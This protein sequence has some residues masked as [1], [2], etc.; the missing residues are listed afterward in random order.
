MDSCG[1]NSEP[2]HSEVRYFIEEEE[3]VTIYPNP[4]D[5]SMTLQY[6]LTNAD[7]GVFK[8]YDVTGKLIKDIQLETN[9]RS[10]SVNVQDLNPGVYIYEITVNERS[11]KKDKLTIIK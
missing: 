5:G 4:N 10:H 6:G 9:S 3:F 2:D 8:I 11:I 1:I 7:L